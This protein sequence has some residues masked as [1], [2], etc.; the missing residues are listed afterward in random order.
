MEGV[1][2]AALDYSGASLSMSVQGKRFASGV[3]DAAGTVP[4]YGESVIDV[5]VT[6]SA[7]RLVGHAMEAFGTERPS[8][9]EYEMQGKLAGPAFK[10]VRFE[11]KG[12]MQ[13]P[14]SLPSSDSA[15]TR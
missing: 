14:E 3:S 5:P 10:S 11:S 15:V 13:L 12:T 4:P 9:I 8:K 2:E 6:I 1:A 7:F